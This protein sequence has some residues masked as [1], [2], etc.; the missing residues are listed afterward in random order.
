MDTV[1]IGEIVT[2]MIMAIA[3]GMDAFS[4]GLGMGMVSLRLRQIFKVGLLIGLFHMIMPLIG[5]TIGKQLSIH[6]ENLATWVGGGLLIL[7]GIQMIVSSFRSRD[8]PFITPKGL[9]I[10]LFSISVSLDSFSVG[11]SL[12]IFG[13]KVIVTILLFGII[14]SLLTWAGLIIGKKA[15]KWFGSYSE[16]FG[17]CIL[18]SFGLKLLV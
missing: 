5:M 14:S 11:L 15:Q 8:E 1:L 3:L 9:G 13:A 7:L 10:W 4:M 12:G 2:L 18:L 16:A 17:G 6:F